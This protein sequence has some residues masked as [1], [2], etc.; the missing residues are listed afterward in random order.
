M[1]L[2]EASA[3]G[4]RSPSEASRASGS[5][6]CAVQYVHQLDEG[7]YFTPTLHWYDC[8]VCRWLTLHI[9]LRVVVIYLPLLLSNC[10]SITV[11]TV[12]LARACPT[13]S[14]GTALDEERLTAVLYCSL[15]C[16]RGFS[17]L[18]CGLLS[19]RRVWS[20][21]C[22]SCMVSARLSTGRGERA[23]RPRAKAR[24]AAT[25]LD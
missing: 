18:Y 24:W 10:S 12:G 23:E 22:H 7:R 19:T 5:V 6:P 16:R 3:Q 15:D 4:R 1:S 11:Y 17:L 8:C 2:P 13:H 25:A 9:V 20:A 21:C 14:H